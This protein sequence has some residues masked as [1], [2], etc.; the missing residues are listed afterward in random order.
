MKRNYL[1]SLKIKIYDEVYEEIGN[2]RVHYF[3]YPMHYNIGDLLIFLGTEEFFKDKNVNVV[4]RYTLY[5]GRSSWIRHKIHKDDVIVFHGGGNFGDI[6]DSCQMLREFIIKKFPNNKIV[7]LPQSVHFNSE[8]RYLESKVIHSR[9]NNLVIFVRDKFSSEKVS[10]FGKVKLMP[11]MAHC[12]LESRFINEVKIRARTT[13]KYGNV[14]LTRTDE[15]KLTIF[16][17]EGHYT[18]ADWFDFIDN[19]TETRRKIFN[20]LL[21][22]LGRYV[23]LSSYVSKQWYFN[24]NQVAYIGGDYLLSGEMVTSDRLHAMIFCE[25]L[26]QKIHMFDNFY[27]KN[28]RYYQ[29]WLNASELIS[30]SKNDK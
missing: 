10:D 4:G 9:H 22:T 12:L 14:Y 7:I 15:E 5:E 24:A 18:M 8:S 30:W 3:D 16:S 6:Y 29:E 25:L 13:S 19:K 27:K 21:R 26:G 23:D 28:S 2:S 1:K 17:G 11:D 20:V